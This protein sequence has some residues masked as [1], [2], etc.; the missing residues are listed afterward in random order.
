MENDKNLQKFPQFLRNAF[1]ERG[2]D[3]PDGTEWEYDGILA[4]RVVEWYDGRPGYA[5]A[6]DFLSKAQ[7]DS[8]AGKKKRGK[9][10]LP[11]DD[12]RYYGISL[13]KNASQL[14]NIFKLPKPKRRLCKGNIVKEGGPIYTIDGEDHVTWWLY[15]NTESL[16][17]ENF[18]IEPE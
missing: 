10:P 15:D 7:K 9:S 13:S 14:K 11:L 8:A 3:F 18:V 12:A 17:Q 5:C 16:L 4:Y 6:S 1:T 2:L